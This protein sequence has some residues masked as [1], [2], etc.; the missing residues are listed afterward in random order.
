[1]YRVQV[2]S[3]A[4]LQVEGFLSTWN[5][6]ALSISPLTTEIEPSLAEEVQYTGLRPPSFFLVDLLAENADGR[7]KPGM[8]GTARIYG[9]RR[10]LAGL[11]WEEIRNFLGRKVW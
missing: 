4:T 7:L 1:M 5:S 8:I 10:S 6:R 9:H 3:E 2:G 11:L